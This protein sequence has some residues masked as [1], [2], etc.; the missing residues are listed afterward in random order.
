M[1]LDGKLV[2]VG[3]SI[4][5]TQQEKRI[6]EIMANK[7]HSY[8]PFAALYA[9]L[10]LEGTPPGK[11]AYIARLSVLPEMW[12]KRVATSLIYEIDLYLLKKEY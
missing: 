4:D 1:K 8:Y 2:A 5:Q 9:S 10:S 11:S 7:D 3:M 12:R 6:Q